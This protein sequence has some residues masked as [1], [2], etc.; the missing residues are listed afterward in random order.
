MLLN[1]RQLKSSDG[2]LEGIIEEARRELARR[3]KERE[4]EAK[5]R[6]AMGDDVPTGGGKGGYQWEMVRC[7]KDCRCN[8][9]K[10]HGPYLYRYFRGKNGKMTSEYIG[11]N[12]ES[13]PDAP[14]RP[15][16][17]DARQLKPLE[18]KEDSDG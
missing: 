6:E 15:A 13:H 1:K 2:E 9:G 10:G 8:D 14:P 18:E 16:P 3:E 11:V 7:K 5:R 4:L 12:A 17:E